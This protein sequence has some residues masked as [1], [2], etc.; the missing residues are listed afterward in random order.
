MVKK[1]IL[2]LSLTLLMLTS[3]VTSTFA[4]TAR[5]EERMSPLFQKSAGDYYNYAPCIIKIGYTARLN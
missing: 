3:L 1:I 5:S 2:C 4:L